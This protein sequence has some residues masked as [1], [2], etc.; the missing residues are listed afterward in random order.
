MALLNLLAKAEANEGQ[1]EDGTRGHQGGE[2]T[3]KTELYDDLMYSYMIP[4]KSTN[5]KGTGGVASNI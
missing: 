5:A 3:C 1:C 2:H 4:F